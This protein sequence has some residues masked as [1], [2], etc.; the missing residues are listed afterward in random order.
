MISLR[1]IKIGATRL[2]LALK[3]RYR[4]TDRNLSPILNEFRFSFEFALSYRELIVS[5]NLCESVQLVLKTFAIVSLA[6][7][8]S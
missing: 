1:F 8:L 3:Q 7:V 6:S 4:C 5:H 2:L